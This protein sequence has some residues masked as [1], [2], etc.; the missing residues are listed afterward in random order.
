[1]DFFFLIFW[2]VSLLMSSSLTFRIF[3]RNGISM[4]KR[5]RI[6]QRTTE[7]ASTSCNFF[8]KVTSSSA[9]TS[10]FFFFWCVLQL[11]VKY[12]IIINIIPT[13][14]NHI[15]YE[16]IILFCLCLIVNYLLSIHRTCLSF[17]LSSSSSSLCINPQD[18]SLFTIYQ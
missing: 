1:M 10:F 8:R 4:T 3:Q 5:S 7:H 16:L 18:L 11:L 2:K 14:W 15:L 13:E 6:I 9:S 17:F 12:I